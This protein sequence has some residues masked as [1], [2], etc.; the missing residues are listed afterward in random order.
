MSRIHALARSLVEPRAC[1]QPG[2]GEECS[3]SRRFGYALPLIGF[4]VPAL[5]LV[6][7]AE[8]R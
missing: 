2:A 7:R 8:R 3:S 6:A 5:V 1:A 4:T